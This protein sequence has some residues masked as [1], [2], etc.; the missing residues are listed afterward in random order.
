MPVLVVLLLSVPVMTYAA[1]ESGLSEHMVLFT[2]AA[3]SLAQVPLMMRLV[4][5]A[6][7]DWSRESGREAQIRSLGARAASAEESLRRDEDRLH[8]LRST[9]SGIGMTYRLL[10]DRR[11][12]I[13]GPARATLESLCETEMARLQRLLT[14][15]APGAAQI[16]DVSAV[17]DPL[18]EA[19]RFRG[20]LVARDGARPLA[21]GRPDDLALIVNTLLEN[22]VRHA[23]TSPVLVQV[24]NYASRVTVSV[25]DQGPGVNAELATRIFERGVRA[26][27]S[28]GQ[29]IGLHVARRLAREMGGDLRLTPGPTSHGATF[30]LSLPSA[31]GMA[32]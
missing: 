28:P 21:L 7:H 17:V 26:P 4:H 27:E 29:G 23:P 12:R 6:L 32:R 11:D 24:Q 15:S 20:I 10:R 25:A 3:W 2:A 13:P 30:T 1:F 31:D 8:E 22:A 16:L 19:L 9:V 14:D 5:R 18:V